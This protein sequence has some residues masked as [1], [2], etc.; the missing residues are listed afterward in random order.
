MTHLQQTWKYFFSMKWGKKSKNQKIVVF[1]R[2]G[3][4]L[5]RFLEVQEHPQAHTLGCVLLKFR[6]LLTKY[7]EKFRY[8]HA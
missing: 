5:V 3:S 8:A 1:V 7:V 4:Y 6:T 2:G